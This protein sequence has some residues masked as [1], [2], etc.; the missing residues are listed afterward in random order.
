MKFDPVIAALPSI[1]STY[2]SVPASIG[3]VL[4]YG[5]GF[6]FLILTFLILPA[7]HILPPKLILSG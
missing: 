3:I 5:P 7:E 4:V 6:T 1:V 2:F